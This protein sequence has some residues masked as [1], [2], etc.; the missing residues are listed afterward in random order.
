MEKVGLYQ[1]KQSKNHWEGE[2]SSLRSLKLKLK[3]IYH[4]KIE[5]EYYQQEFASES[6]LRCDHF[7]SPFESFDVPFFSMILPL[8]HLPRL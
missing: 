3:G 8:T 7:I 2:I 5:L 4:K 1:N 6:F